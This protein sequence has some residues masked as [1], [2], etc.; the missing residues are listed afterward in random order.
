M[1]WNEG[2]AYVF[3]AE[4]PEPPVPAAGRVTL[5]HAAPVPRQIDRAP[6]RARL[7]HEHRVAIAVKTVAPGDRF[8]I[9]GENPLAAREPS[10]E[11]Q[12]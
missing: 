6:R 11:H 7:Q 8:A 3:Y 10:Y 12:Q 1:F 5:E 2:G 9:G 4:S